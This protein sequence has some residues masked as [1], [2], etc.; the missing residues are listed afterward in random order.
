[1]AQRMRDALAVAHRL[2]AGEPP[3]A[4][5][6]S[7]RLPSRAAD[8][9]I[10]DVQATDVQHLGEALGTLADLELDTR[11]GSPTTAAR[12]PLAGAGEDTLALS[13][14]IAICRR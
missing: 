13:S 1:M 2:A 8:R 5:K 14:I 9:L 12:T 11:G 10:A 3:S 7:L 6:R 4:I